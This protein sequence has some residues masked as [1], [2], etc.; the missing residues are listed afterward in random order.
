MD[1]WQKGKNPLVEHMQKTENAFLTM[2][3]FPLT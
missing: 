1:S 3:I 2:H